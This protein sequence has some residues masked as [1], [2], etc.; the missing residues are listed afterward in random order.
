MSAFPNIL[1]VFSDQQRFCDLGCYGNREVYTPNIDAWA[2]NAVVF[3]RFYS[4]CPV[5]VP[6]RGTLL[7]GTYPLRHGAITNDLRIRS[8]ARSIAHILNE[9]GYNTVYFGKWH[10]GG[11]PRDQ[12]I[13][14]E[15][16][17][18]FQYWRGCNC[19]HNYMKAYYD[20]N[21][22][23]RHFREGYEPHIQTCLAEEYI[24]S[25]G[26]DKP[27][28][29]FLSFGTPHDPYDLVPSGTSDLYDETKITLR[30]NVSFPVRR[31]PSILF[32]E[33]ALRRQIKGYY[34]H[35]TEL[36]TMMG[37]LFAAL[38]VRGLYDN[39]IIVYTSDHGNMLGS[40]GLTDKQLPY[41][42]SVHIPFIVSYGKNLHS[43]IRSGT[44]SLVDVVPTLLPLAGI[45]I[46]AESF[47]GRDASEAVRGTDRKGFAYLTEYIPCHQAAL[48]GSGEWRAVI[49]DNYK[50]IRSPDASG[51]WRIELYDLSSD[52]GEQRNLA[53]NAGY[54]ETEADL[55]AKLDALVAEHDGY[56][57][58][59]EFIR[60][61]GL[62][63]QWN[64]SQR[65]FHLEELKA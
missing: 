25:V 30:D 20:D 29:L 63:G 35:I 45:D 18:G 32:D 27:F 16:R 7:T 49:S 11:V 26:T 37:R 22:D 14:E 43:G 56:L 34:A 65:Y 41:E 58:W 3:D 9:N 61:N 17:L 64:E 24:A 31:S 44:A 6:A 10:L 38:D 21:D 51:V 15:N 39:T 4:N 59:R 48:R 23:I 46:S 42:E 47:D 8:D 55:T 36:D 40:H 60:Y 53:G 62:V 33:K 12:F 54:S 57:D 28:A 1:F 13:T 50:L 52:R 2:E 5:C 19:N